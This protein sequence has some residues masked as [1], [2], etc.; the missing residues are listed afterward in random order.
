MAFCS[1]SLFYGREKEPQRRRKSSRA[2]ELRERRLAARSLHRCR[3]RRRRRR[4]RRFPHSHSLPDRFE[5]RITKHTVYFCGSVQVLDAAVK[6][7][8]ADQ[9]VFDRWFPDS[10][11]HRGKCLLYEP[12][13][14]SGLTRVDL[15]H[16]RRD[17]NVIKAS[18]AE[19]WIK[20]SPNQRVTA[21]ACLQ[22]D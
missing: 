17:S 14:Q 4:C 9:P 11:D 13:N 6:V 20:G 5:E 1:I 16:P 3:R 18:V 19:Q 8:F 22:L 15:N 2:A 10:F 21:C 12:F 7:R